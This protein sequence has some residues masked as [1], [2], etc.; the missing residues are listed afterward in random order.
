M[1][2]KQCSEMDHNICTQLQVFASLEMYNKPEA[3]QAE[4]GV[5][6]FLETGT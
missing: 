5:S 6:S 2:T 1:M 3:V 4:G